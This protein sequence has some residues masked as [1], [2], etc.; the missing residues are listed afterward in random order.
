M[1]EKEKIRTVPFI[2]DNKSAKFI[3]F[4]M[5]LKTFILQRGVVAK[6]DL[7]HAPFTQ[8]HPKGVR[9]IFKPPEINEAMLLCR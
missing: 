4:I 5:T 7:I 9:G 2:P 6:K 1:K 8:L 3:Q